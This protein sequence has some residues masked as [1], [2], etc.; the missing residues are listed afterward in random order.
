ID[1]DAGLRHTMNV[2][3]KDCLLDASVP[4]LSDY[5]RIDEV[6]EKSQDP[7]SYEEEEYDDSDQDY[8]EEDQDM[9]ESIDY[10]D[11][12]FE[13]DDAIKDEIKVE[14]TELL[15][16]TAQNIIDNT[17]MMLNMRDYDNTLKAI[18]RSLEILQ[19]LEERTEEVRFAM[20]TALLLKDEVLGK[21]GQT[22]KDHF[23]L[24]DEL[25]E[26]LEKVML[27]EERPLHQQ[28]SI[29]QAESILRPS[30]KTRSSEI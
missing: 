1:M 2:T 9:D 17:R 24:I 13:T 10:Q 22:E 28:R 11:I 21:H 19:G 6:L 15:V 14:E 16:E 23:E 26:E 4:D 18:G 27:I 20:L 5:P 12:E 25:L 7:D 3:L 30:K 8:D 29:E